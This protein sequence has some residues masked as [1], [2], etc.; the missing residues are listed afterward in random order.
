MKGGIIMAISSKQDSTSYSI[1]PSEKCGECQCDSC[2]F[3]THE[4]SE[5]YYIRYGTLNCH[6]CDRCDFCT[7]SQEPMTGCEEY[8][9]SEDY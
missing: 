2:C 1:D 8:M 6:D 9:Y 5:I 4:I 3:R 7:K